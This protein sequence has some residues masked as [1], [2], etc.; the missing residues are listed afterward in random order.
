MPKGLHT[1][2][3]AVLFASA[4]DM[5]AVAAALGAPG[6]EPAAAEAGWMGG[7]PR[8]RLALKGHG[9]VIVE[10]F[11][12]P[13]PDGMGDPQGDPMLFGA[14][15]MGFFG[16]FAWPEGLR[17]AAQQAWGWRGAADAVA[18]HG[19]FVRL[20]ASQ[21]RGNDDPVIPEGYDALAELTDLTDITRRIAALPGAL[22]VFDPNGETLTPP[23]EWG[24]L[25]DGAKR[26]DRPPIELWTNVRFVRLSDHPGWWLMDVVGLGQLDR[27]DLE[28]C[29]P[30]DGV[31]PNDLARFLRNVSLYVIERGDVFLDGHTIEGPGGQ[32]TAWVPD[33]S[34]WAPPRPVVRFFPTAAEPPEALRRGIGDQ[35]AS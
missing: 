35:G 6:A 32:W 13:W 12:R 10:A 34:L 33:E 27:M 3:M 16:P 25:I 23:A 18:A 29:C 15:S 2:S 30:G 31:E 7:G 14:W 8:V 20:T 1:Q 11:D 21:V 17:R 22:A 28:A 5:A 4:P 9:T 26:E 24:R 19:G